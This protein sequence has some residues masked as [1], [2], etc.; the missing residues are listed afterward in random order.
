MSDKLGADI[1]NIN[2]KL[3]ENVKDIGELNQSIPMSQDTNDNKLRE[4]VSS[5]KQQKIERMAQVEGIR[6]KCNESKE[7]VRNLG[8]RSQRGKLRIDGIIEYQEKSQDNTEELLKI[9]GVKS[10]V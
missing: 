2:G 4:I 10:W 5:I 3:K 1:V 7:K 9:H 6:K 8:D